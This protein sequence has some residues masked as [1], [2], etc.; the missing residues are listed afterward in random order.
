[1]IGTPG[2]SYVYDVNTNTLEKLSDANPAIS[3]ADMATVKPIS[4][5]TRDGLTIHGYLALPAGR[6]P[7]G[8]ACIVNPHGGP[9][10]RDNWGYNP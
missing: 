6:E 1:M 10:Q 9:W 8:L 7:K 5:I 2:A 4:Y 3:E